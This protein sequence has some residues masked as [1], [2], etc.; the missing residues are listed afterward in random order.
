MDRFY[1]KR[2]V[3]GK[4]MGDNYGVRGVGNS[5]SNGDIRYDKGNNNNN[6]NNIIKDNNNNNNNNNNPN[7]NTTAIPY[8]NL[9]NIVGFIILT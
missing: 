5:N 8:H 6:N 3:V 2:F 4:K 9:F 7:P 1:Q